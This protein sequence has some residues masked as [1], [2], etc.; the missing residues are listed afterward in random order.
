VLF[1]DD[2]DDW[3]SRGDTAVGLTVDAAD[4]TWPGH[5]GV[6]TTLVDR[7]RFEPARTTVVTCGPEVMMRHVVREFA[8]RGV[9]HHDIW[10]SSERNMACGMA[11]CGHCQWGPLLVCRDGPVVNAAVALPLIEVRGW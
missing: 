3:A 5:V 7:I 9:D 2:L 10:L 6:V 11:L 8:G 4:R 1:G